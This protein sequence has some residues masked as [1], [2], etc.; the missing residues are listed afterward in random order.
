MQQADY[1]LQSGVRC[2]DDPPISVLT[3]PGQ[4]ELTTIPLDCK[5][6]ASIIV[7]PFNASFDK[8]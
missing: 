1:R 3:H 8:Q 5:A 4:M 6:C 2:A 7:A